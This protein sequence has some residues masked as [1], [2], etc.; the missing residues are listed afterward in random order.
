MKQNIN[1]LLYA[2]IFFIKDAKNTQWKFSIL[3]RYLWENGIAICKKMK[4]HTYL[5]IYSRNYTN[6]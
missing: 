1:L 5:V 2:Q 3:N 6:K 4:M